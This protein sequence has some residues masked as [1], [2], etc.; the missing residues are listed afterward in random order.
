MFEHIVVPTC[1]ENDVGNK[2]GV[3]HEMESKWEEEECVKTKA[4]INREVWQQ[5]KER[6]RDQYEVERLEKEHMRAFI[7]DETE[8]KREGDTCVKA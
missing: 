4:D 3:K 6:D 7:Y 8:S 1:T 2:D 5:K